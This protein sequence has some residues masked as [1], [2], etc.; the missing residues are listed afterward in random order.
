MLQ[1]NAPTYVIFLAS[2]Q[3]VLPKLPD[4]LQVNAPTYV[5]FLAS[6]HPVILK[7]LCLD[8]FDLVSSRSLQ[9]S[10]PSGIATPIFSLSSLEYKSLRMVILTIILVQVLCCLYQSPKYFIEIWYERPFSLQHAIVNEFELATA[11]S[12]KQRFRG[13][14]GSLGCPWIIR[15]RTQLDGSVRVFSFVLH[16]YVSVFA[17]PNILLNTF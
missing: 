12:D 8:C 5:N 1:V 7:Y 9:S 2:V 14:C 11:H 4:V 17:I 16:I 13:N 10:N 6:V 3:P 15:A